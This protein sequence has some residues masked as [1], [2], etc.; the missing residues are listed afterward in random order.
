[1]LLFVM[2]VSNQKTYKTKKEHTK[3]TAETI[4]ERMLR[5]DERISALQSNHP[6]ENSDQSK[7]AACKQHPFAKII[8][9]MDKS[10]H[11]INF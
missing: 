7:D 11:Y 10:L 1:M 8:C 9:C 3:A 4:V 5:W 6:N 2:V